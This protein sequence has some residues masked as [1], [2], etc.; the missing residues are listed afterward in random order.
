MI[1]TKNY[2]EIHERLFKKINVIEVL[3]TLKK[4]NLCMC[5]LFRYKYLLRKY[6]FC[7]NSLS[8]QDIQFWSRHQDIHVNVDLAFICFSSTV[9]CQG[10]VVQI[11]FQSKTFIVY[12]V[13]T[14]VTTLREEI[15]ETFKTLSTP[16]L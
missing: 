11:W 2:N 12:D 16:L 6:Q 8:L 4:K 15:K 9:L 5:L 14:F 13:W 3:S 10:A 1:I 7:C